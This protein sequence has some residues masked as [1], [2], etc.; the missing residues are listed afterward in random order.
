MPSSPHRKLR[1]I[2]G[3]L[4]GQYPMGGVAWDY[5]HYVLGLAELGHDVYYH[6]DTNTWPYN[7]SLRQPSDDGVYNASFIGDFF[8]KYA[9][10]LAEKWHYRLLKDKAFGMSVEAFDDVAKSADVYLNVSG[11]CELPPA[12]G[13]HC[14]K[15]FLDSDPGYNQMGLQDELDA[16]GPSAR[17]YAEVMQHD[18]HLTY[19][20]NIDHPDCKLPKAGIR[21]IPT[22]PIATLG[23]WNDL[24]DRPLPA[25]APF[26]TVMT[27]DLSK[28]PKRLRYKG[29]D[30][31]DKRP[32][33]EKFITLPKHL[34]GVNLTLAIGNAKGLEPVTSNGWHVTDS[35]DA[36]LTPEAY[37]QFIG[38]SAGEWSIAKNV[39]AATNSGWFSC[40][41]CCYL[42]AGRPVVVQDTKWSRYVIPGDGLAAFDT[43]EQAIDGVQRMAADP[44]RH[45]RGAYEIARQFLAPDRVLPRMIDDVFAR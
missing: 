31:F 15:V 11:V 6:E 7:P 43:M 39:Y 13:Q 5:F 10:P 16:H 9:P 23:H 29:V 2:V 34:P 12:L 20:E 24:L 30:Y 37:R 36:S 38:N 25:G 1:I 44:K 18:V 45:R 14:R 42:A 26:T 17:R 40:R 41:T 22:R 35:H 4:V 27:L 32:E 21:W 3:G 33:F 28:E 8:A 19:A